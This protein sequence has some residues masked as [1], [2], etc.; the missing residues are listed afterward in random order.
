[1]ASD[2]PTFSGRF[3]D[4]QHAGSDSVTIELRPAGLA[5]RRADETISETVGEAVTNTWFWHYNRLETARPIR[6]GDVDTL[7]HSPETPGASLF[8][9]DVEFVRRLAIEAD[10]ISHGSWLWRYTR[11][12]LVML[13]VFAAIGG[14]I[15]ALD[16]SPSR[17]LANMMSDKMRSNIG[18]RIFTSFVGTYPV[19]S[20]PDGDAALAKMTARL[21]D[22]DNDDAAYNTR[23]VNWSLE[24][25]FALP[26]R[27]II[28]TS[29]LIKKAKSAEEVAGVLA[30]EI[31]HVVKLHPE[32]GV[33]RAMGLTV[34]AQFIFAGGSE[35]LGSIGTL[36]VA[37]RYNR[38]AEREADA[39]GLKIL[40]KAKVSPAPLAGFFERVM[41]KNPFDVAAAKKSDKKSVEEKTTEEK[42]PASRGFTKSLELL[43]THPPTRERIENIRARA[44]YT[45]R[46]VLDENEW[47]ALQKICATTETAKEKEPKKETEE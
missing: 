31:G 36:L 17:A 29:G 23:V 18:E 7:V 34:A 3:S 46:P 42:G 2:H 8:V 20:T 21:A 1:M 41:K 28:L 22:A 11:P 9:A 6:R 12:A 35:T 14:G 33:V 45:T 30:H 15:W 37:L 47:T 19:C 43:S 38:K 27:K 10:Q 4:G 5:F 13:V 39:V 16:L 44:T 24:N 32:T 40:R 26:G 25:A